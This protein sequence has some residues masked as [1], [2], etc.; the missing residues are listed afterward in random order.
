MSII[1]LA[2]ASDDA[3]TES[4]RHCGNLI[5]IVVDRCDQNAQITDRSANILLN[6][7]QQPWFSILG[8]G[9]EG[10]GLV[11]AVCPSVFDEHFA[12]RVELQ[13]PAYAPGDVGQVAYDRGGVADLFQVRVG[14]FSRRSARRF[15]AAGMRR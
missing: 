5:Y 13:L 11:V 8:S 7:G 1:P 4:R 9:A 14:T 6:L 10:V 2:S 15:M 12:G 3:N